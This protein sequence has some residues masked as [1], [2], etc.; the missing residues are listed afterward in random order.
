MQI[1]QLYHILTKHYPMTQ[2]VQ[3][4][5]LYILY[6]VQTGIYI[7]LKKAQLDTNDPNAF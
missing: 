2:I 3:R 1:Y 4:L 5:I 6:M 7:K